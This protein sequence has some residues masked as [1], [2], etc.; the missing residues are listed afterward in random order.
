MGHTLKEGTS[1]IVLSCAVMRV[2][3]LRSYFHGEYI[4]ILDDGT[5]LKLS[6]TYRDSLESIA[7]RL[8]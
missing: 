1:I 5:Q 8:G 2:S 3:E 7:G 4:V 6:R